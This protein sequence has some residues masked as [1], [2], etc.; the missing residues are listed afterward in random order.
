MFI[1]NGC[2]FNGNS[3]IAELWA[4]LSVG[5]VTDVILDPNTDNFLRVSFN[6]SVLDLPCEYLSVDVVDVL[7]TR[8]ESVSQNIN[9][10]AI[11]GDGLLQNYI[12]RNDDSNN[13]FK[14]DEHHDKE[15][16]EANGIQAI[17]LDAALTA[18]EV[19]GEEFNEREKAFGWDPTSYAIIDGIRTEFKE[20]YELWTMYA[21]FENNAEGWVSGP[22]LQLKAT[23][24]SEFVTMAYQKSYKLKN[25]LKKYSGRI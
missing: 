21:D 3:I 22:F 12:G 15:E 11:D 4:F 9:K 18:A 5:Y 17:N 24:V 2:N 14:I 19:K 10:W 13:Q 8:K 7:G 16:L 25:K 1:S 23:E 6:I 20:F